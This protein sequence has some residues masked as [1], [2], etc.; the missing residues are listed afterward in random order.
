MTV[1]I[2]TESGATGCGSAFRL[3]A[4]RNLL[5]SRT[6]TAHDVLS[7][8][9]NH[10]DAFLNERVNLRG[11]LTEEPLHLSPVEDIFFQQETDLN[12]QMNDVRDLVDSAGPLLFRKTGGDRQNRQEH[13]GHGFDFGSGV[14]WWLAPGFPDGLL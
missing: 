1:P 7:R 11:S 12:Q 6:R 13:A 9:Q 8:R 5:I 4:M 14:S 2:E 10:S 3:L